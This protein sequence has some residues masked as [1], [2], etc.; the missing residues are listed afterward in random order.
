MSGDVLFVSWSKEKKTAG[1]FIQC[2]S[3]IFEYSRLEKKVSLLTSRRVDL[4][5]GSKVR[6]CSFIFLCVFFHFPAMARDQRTRLRGPGDRKQF[7]PK[8][9][10]VWSRLTKL[11]HTK[12]VF[13]NAW[14]RP[15]R[16][17]SAAASLYCILFAKDLGMLALIFGLRRWS[18]NC[19]RL[20]VVYP[21]IAPA[22][23]HSREWR[24]CSPEFSTHVPLQR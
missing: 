8:N 10:H 14:Q 2:S 20:I 16:F 9:L 7:C 11:S 23:V 5:V 12:T 21:R 3:T 1:Y 24:D 15:D 13:W 17:H 6:V 19:G 4:W 22:R 18:A